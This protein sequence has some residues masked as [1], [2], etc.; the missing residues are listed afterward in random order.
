MSY[1][2]MS[3]EIEKYLKENNLP[4]RGKESDTKEETARRMN[5]YYKGRDFIFNKWLNEKKYKELISVAHQ[6][7][8]GEDDFFVPLAKYFVKE[9]ELDWLK[10]LCERK[11][12]FN[13]EDTLNCLK[14]VMEKYQNKRII[15][16]LSEVI[17]L[18]LEK[19]KKGESYNCIGE[20]KSHYVK[21]LNKFDQYIGFLEQMDCHEYLKQ[22]KE[23]QNKTGNFTIKLNDLKNIKIKL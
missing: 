15:E 20:L 17:L 19:Y 12:R 3:K 8:F 1:T 11:V 9:N 5:A 6:G 2:K 21:T 4:W 22:I 7:W 18:D 23:M 13:I 16:I 10:F 14:N